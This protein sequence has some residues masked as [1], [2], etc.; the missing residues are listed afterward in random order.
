M[1][2]RGCCCWGTKA[3]MSSGIWKPGSATGSSGTKYR[4]AGIWMFGTGRETI[5]MLGAKLTRHTAI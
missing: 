3:T 1:P 4:N 5:W 2:L